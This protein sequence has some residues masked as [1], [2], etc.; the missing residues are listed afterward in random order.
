MLYP[1]TPP[2]LFNSNVVEKESFE[3]Y[4][5]IWDIESVEV[6]KKELKVYQNFET[7]LEIKG[8][9]YSTKLPFKST[10]EFL[11]D[12]YVTSEK[13]LSLLKCKLDNTKLME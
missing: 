8:G 10:F 5:K 6:T 1:V 13:R 11:Q 4:S 9:R 3:C 7:K 2:S 12:N